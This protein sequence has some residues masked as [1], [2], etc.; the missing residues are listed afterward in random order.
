MKQTL[1][2]LEENVSRFSCSLEINTNNY[3][4]LAI[5][6]VCGRCSELPMPVI[7]ARE[8][9]VRSHKTRQ[10]KKEMDPREL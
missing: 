9:E 10:L 6:F 7:L 2:K 5:L 4:R 3:W 1:V 8:C